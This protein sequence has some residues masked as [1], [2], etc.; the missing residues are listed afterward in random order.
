MGR[1]QHHCPVA[2]N[3]TKKSIKGQG[4]KPHAL[5]FLP[6]YLTN[7]FLFFQLH[8]C[9][10]VHTIGDISAPR[11]NGKA[12]TPSPCRQQHYTEGGKRARYET[13]PYT[14]STPLSHLQIFNFSV[15]SFQGGPHNWGYLRPQ[16]EWEGGDTLALS[17]TTLPRRR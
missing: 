13:M 1:W 12:A 11:M 7:K 8:R 3:I 9:R 5:H 16:N 15:T 14:F 17:P 2:N 6:H 4:T 10:A